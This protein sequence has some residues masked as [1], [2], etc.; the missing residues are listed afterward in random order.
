MFILILYICL[1]AWQAWEGPQAPGQYSSSGIY[2]GKSQQ[3]N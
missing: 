1:P 3:N 2:G